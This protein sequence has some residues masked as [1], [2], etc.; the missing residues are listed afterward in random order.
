MLGW[1]LLEWDW[2]ALL[3]DLELRIMVVESKEWREVG[4]VHLYQRAFEVSIVF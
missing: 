3:S 1:C 4:I 2:G